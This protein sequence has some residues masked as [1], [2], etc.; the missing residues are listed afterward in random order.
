VA[1][2]ISDEERIVRFFMVQPPAECAL[3]QKTI[4]HI[5]AN[6]ND[7]TQ[8]VKKERKKRASRGAAPELPLAAG[9]ASGG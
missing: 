9:G 5:L 2:K 1:K 7:I 3:M 6:R 8:P 4:T